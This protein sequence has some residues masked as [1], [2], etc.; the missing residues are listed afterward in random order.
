LAF[1][2]SGIHAAADPK[3][4]AIDALE[5]AQHNSLIDRFSR[6]AKDT[7]T[8]FGLDAQDRTCGI[9]GTV[10]KIPQVFVLGYLDTA[11]GLSDRTIPEIDNVP[12]Q[13]WQRGFVNPWD[14]LGSTLIASSIGRNIRRLGP[15]RGTRLD[16]ILGR[17]LW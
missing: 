14:P 7:N 17:D 1:T 16:N 12:L 2:D 8:T 6:L 4:F 15:L 9:N 11:A 13:T 5:G 10:R 3:K